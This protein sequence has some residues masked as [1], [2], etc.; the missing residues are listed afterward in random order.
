MCAMSPRLLRPVASGFDPRR[1][2]GLVAWFD[3]TDNSKITTDTGVSVWTDKANGYTLEQSTGANQPTLSTIG[4][5]QAFSYNGSSQFLRSTSAGLVGTPN[6]TG[7]KPYTGF[8]VA[9]RATA[10]NSC[11]AGF[12][13]SASN[14]IM[15]NFAET[16]TGFFLA[17]RHGI[18]A[19][20]VPSSAIGYAANTP[21]VINSVIAST[22]VMRS[23]GAQILS[24]AST[25]TA[26]NMTCNRFT[27]GVLDRSSISDYYSGLVG[28]VLIYNRVLTATEI[29][30]VEKY[31][32]RK[33]GAT[34]A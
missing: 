32:A 34:L 7:I 21:A 29:A 23:N 27:V 20:F 11:A 24:T 16:R 31:L 19:Q 28:D 9:Q 2:A 3:S 1:I 8:V 13:S 22:Y 33:F 5:A 17:L 4:G 10:A 18:T 30:T 6:G 12:F 14:G 26:D 15:S 25:T